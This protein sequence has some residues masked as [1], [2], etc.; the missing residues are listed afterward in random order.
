MAAERDGC[1]GTWKRKLPFSKPR[2]SD[3][4]GKL[5]L[6]QSKIDEDLTSCIIILHSLNKL[7][8]KGRSWS[9]GQV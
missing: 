3:L 4:C 7:T 6:L 9:V 5:L 2:S 1:Q 8:K